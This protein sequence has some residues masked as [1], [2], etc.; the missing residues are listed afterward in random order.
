MRLILA[1]LLAAVVL[2]PLQAAEEEA[3][4]AKPV[5][6]VVHGG[7]GT[8][9]R[10]ELDAEQEKQIHAALREALNQGHAILTAGGSSL[11]AVTAAVKVLEDSPLFNAGKGAVFNC[12]GIN[13]LD[14]AIMD[15][16]TLNAGA[17]AGLK[18]TKNPV[19][20]ARL[21]ME[22]S[23]HVLL[24]GE[25]AESFGRQHDIAM[26]DPAY[27]QTEQRR[28]QLDDVQ[29]REG[30]IGCGD[31]QE[32]ED[33]DE[34]R[35][36]TV[37]AVA[38]DASGNLAAA[39]STG[40]MTN[41]RF[42]RVGDVPVVGAGTY[43]DNATAAISATGHGEYFIRAVAAHDIAARMAYGGLSLAE[44]ADAVVMKKLRE[45]GGGGGVIAVDGN[46]NIA[47]PFNTTGMYR[48]YIDTKGETK[49]AIFAD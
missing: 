24:I 20:L 33:F 13:E 40:G 18:Q 38:L 49:T 14:A 48:G 19:E 16:S 35:Y 1:G 31:E 41:K 12:A 22:E 27:F 26:V 8:I 7:A 21:V 29:K 45:M 23:P 3:A 6:I 37:G 39:T 46:G 44:A 15:G 36:G 34:D 11:D 28:R 25:G 4:P 43:A 9:S 32:V 17:V 5:A 10:E 42:G 30:T 47:M 2:A